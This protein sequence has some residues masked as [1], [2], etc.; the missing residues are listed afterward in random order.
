MKFGVFSTVTKADKRS[1][2]QLFK[3]N[4]EQV[5]YAE[6]LGFDSFWFAEHHFS[7]YSMIASRKR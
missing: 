2:H 4:L 1:V 5:A 7:T 6:D 3:E